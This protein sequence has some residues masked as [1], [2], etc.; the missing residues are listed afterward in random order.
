MMCPK[1]FY[2]RN[3][4]NNLFR[5][6]FASEQCASLISLNE[7]FILF[8]WLW[9]MNSIFAFKYTR[10][11][12]VSWVILF[13]F[14]KIIYHDK[15]IFNYHDNWHP[16]HICCIS[17][18]VTYVRQIFYFIEKPVVSRINWDHIVD[19]NFRLLV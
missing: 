7:I 15:I 3:R 6:A 5:L 10:K 18:L 17:F 9:V 14:L 4:I 16:I 8:C 12:K 19:Y 11:S 13:C 2:F 1:C